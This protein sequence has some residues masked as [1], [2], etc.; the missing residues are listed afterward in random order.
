VLPHA[1]Q[2]VTQYVTRD[3]WRH[4]TLYRFRRLAPMSSLAGALLDVDMPTET[5]TAPYVKQDEEMGDL[6]GEDSNVDYVHH[7]WGSVLFQLVL[8][9][10]IFMPLYQPARTN[11]FQLRQAL[12]NRVTLP[13]SHHHPRTMVCPRPTEKEG[14]LWSTKKTKNPIL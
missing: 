5:A 8:P 13:R 4:L 3:G 6:F 11:R 9:T 7:T 1:A 14:R 12:R 2:R 10:L